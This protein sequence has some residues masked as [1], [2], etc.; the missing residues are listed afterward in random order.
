MAAATVLF[1]TIARQSDQERFLHIV[2]LAKLSRDFVAVHP[3]QAE[4]QENDRRT[5]LPSGLQRRRAIVH[6]A[7]LVAFHFQEGGQAV[8]G[9]PV[10][11]DNQYARGTS[12]GCG[13]WRW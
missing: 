8:G 7:N 2:L 5:L 13:V 1:L 10:I 3:R 6:L 4:I 11:I 12:G 9:I